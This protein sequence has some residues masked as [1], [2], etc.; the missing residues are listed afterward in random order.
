MIG[1]S[2]HTSQCRCQNNM[3]LE[4]TQ[5]E[6]SRQAAKACHSNRA[7]LH[8]MITR[9]KQNTSEH[10]LYCLVGLYPFYLCLFRLGHFANEYILNF[11]LQSSKQTTAYGPQLA[12]HLPHANLIARSRGRLTWAGLFSVLAQHSIHSL[13]LPSGR[14]SYGFCSIQL[15]LLFFL[16]NIL[17]NNFFLIFFKNL[18][19]KF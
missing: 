6:R 7:P 8:T 11:W 19:W 9:K 5:S 2:H 4:Q 18:I 13:G 15:V 10:G 1:I 17:S 12:T 16:N 14:F 3:L